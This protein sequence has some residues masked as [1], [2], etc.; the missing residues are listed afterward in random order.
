[1]QLKSG[2][3]CCLNWA[4]WQEKTANYYFNFYKRLL[5]GLKLGIADARFSATADRGGQL[6]MYSNQLSEKSAFEK[7]A[8]IQ[9][10]Y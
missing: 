6:K 1:L 7:L 5:Q 4:Y 8:S 2:A 3:N 10:T 9:P